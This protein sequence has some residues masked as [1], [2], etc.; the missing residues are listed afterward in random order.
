MTREEQD[1]ALLVAVKK[2]ANETID[3]AF[4]EKLDARMESNTA[5]KALID[6]QK[7]LTDS[8]AMEDIVKI[9][10][11]VAAFET[12]VTELKEKM[13]KKPAK[14]A[15][16]FSGS[17][18]HLFAKGLGE[19]H[20]KGMFEKLKSGSVQQLMVTTSK[21]TYGEKV[22]NP[23]SDATSV[24]PIGS[25]VAFS[26]TQFEPGL[27]RVTRRKPF[28]TQLVDLARTMEKIVA[29]VE[30]TNIDTGVAFTTAEGASQ[31]GNYGSFRW[32]ENSANVQKIDALSKVTKEMLDD[33][34]AAQGEVNTEILELI[35]LKLD[36]QVLN[37]NG[38]SPNLKGILQY[39]QAFSNFGGLSVAAPNNYDALVAAILQI[40]ANGTVVGETINIFEPTDIVMHPTDI[41]QMELTKDT[42][43]RYVMQLYPDLAAG[44]KT[45][46]NCKI[47]EN[48]GMTQGSFLV[49][50]ATKSHVRIRE[51]AQ[52]T[53]GYVG[54]DFQD[55]LVTIK[56]V[57]RAAHFIKTNQ[58]K[59]FVSDTFANAQAALV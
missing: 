57:L 14:K 32:T 5:I 26:L 42:L 35:A 11:S 30:Q 3:K 58:V 52:I 13:E 24:V 49:M 25:G 8:K 16:K 12:A 23:M 28:I 21:N 1:A 33:L 44:G 15:N 51:D 39:A 40:R 34:Q 22:D 36:S 10:A 46:A 43:N 29:W 48:I 2:A 50:D 9:K 31:S 54:N 4:A 7:Q 20:A 56:G 37:G 38:T 45:L 18:G 17:L 53:M 19:L 6:L 41:A 59:A 55:D 27:T 47:T